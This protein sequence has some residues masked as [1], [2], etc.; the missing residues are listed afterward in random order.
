MRRGIGDRLY[1]RGFTLIELLVVIAIIAILA[2]ILFPVF[3]KAREKARQS[4]CMNNLRQMGLASR[5][6]V[7]DHDDVLVP[8]YLYSRHSASG[9]Q[10]TGSP[11]LRWFPDLLSPYVKNDQIA[12]CPNWSELYDFGRQ[13][14]P[15]GEG[16]N[17][18]VLRYSYGANNW[19]WWPRGESDDPDLIGVMGVNRPGLNINSTE[20]DIKNPANAIMILDGLSMEIWTPSQHDYARGNRPVPTD[21]G[22]A[23][24]LVHLRHSGGFNT[25]FVD[26]HTK[27]LRQTTQDMWAA[28]PQNIR[29]PAARS[30]LR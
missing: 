4:S 10:P 5:S 30:A 8:C 18:R 7:A 20:A 1:F 19:H 11:V 2:A 12:V 3:A 16:A 28:D 6:Y 14:F 15:P 23:L 24:G 9:T 29:D 21:G 25:L 27:W 13:S 26:S 17:L 22:P